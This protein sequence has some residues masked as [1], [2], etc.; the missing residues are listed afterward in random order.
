[1]PVIRIDGQ[2]YE[3][4]EGDNLLQAC[5]G[6]GLDLPYFCWHPAM[7]SI[8]A[9]RQCA[10]VQYQNAEDQ[11]GRLVMSCM[12]PVSDGAIFSLA[13]DKAATF[14]QA[15]IES[16]MTNHPH[17]CPVCAEGGEC[18][19]QDMTVM[20]GHRDRHYR[21]LKRTHRNQ[22]L[23]PLIQHEMNRCIACYRCT[24]YYRDYA[25]GTDL[26][27]MAAHNHVYFGRH[28]DGVLES[29]F[30]GNLVEV[31]PTGVF[32]D[33]PLQQEYTRKWDLQSAPSLCTGCA[34][35]CNT[36]AGER[37][38]K[39]KR[40][41]NRYN[42]EVNGYFLCDR[43]RF[44]ASFVNHKQ[45]LD[46]AGRRSANGRFDA[47]DS[48]QA[49]QHLAAACQRGGLAGIGSPRASVEANFLLR[50][51]VGA[52]NYSP[53]FSA[54]EQPLVE[55]A[56]SLQQ[57]TRALIP[58]IKQ[59]ESADAVFILGEDVTN[60]A[61]RIALALRQ[62]VR[63]IAYTMAAQLRLLPWQDA[64]VRN[65]AQEQ[66]NPLFIAA[67]ADTRLD[68]VAAAT[69]HLAPA[70]IARLGHAVAARIRT[71]RAHS[72][73]TLSPNKVSPNK[74]PPNEVMDEALQQQADT[75]ASALLDAKRP[76]LLSGTGCGSA[77]V[78]AAAADIA[79]ALGSPAAA[80]VTKGNVNNSDSDSDSDAENSSTT[81][82]KVDSDAAGPA[83]MLC[84]AVPEAN[85]LGQALLTGPSAPTLEALTVR[86]VGGEIQTLL[87]L[88]ND[89]YRRGP[90]A[91]IERLLQHVAEIIVI[92]SL[93]NPTLSASTLALPAASFAESEGTLVS[94]E[95]RAQRHFPVFLP[96][97]ERR[98][99]WQ[100]LLA[101]LQAISHPR[102]TDLQHFDDVTN[103]CASD[104]AALANITKAAPD[105]LFRNAGLAKVPRQPHRYSGRTAM[106]AN[107]SV[108]EPKQAAD[109]D[110][111]LAFSME[112]VNQFQPGALL[113]FVWAPGWNSNQSL[114][115]F[116]T[117]VGGPLKG[118]TAGAKLLQ[119]TGAADD[120]AAPLSPSA[121]KPVTGQWLL[122]PRYKIFGSEE[123]SAHSPAIA[124]LLLPAYLEITAADA[125][126]LQVDEGD[127]VQVMDSASGATLA[128]L[129]VRINDTMADGCAG[130]SVGH[131][132][133]Q[134]SIFNLV[135]G[136]GVALQKADPWQRRTQSAPGADLIATDSPT[137]SNTAAPGGP[138]H[139]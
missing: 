10:V 126:R 113:P 38:G 97:K 40:I 129:E 124:Q 132:A 57:Q 73:A 5:L 119:Q 138:N 83:V 100:W 14:R 84:L 15:I 32:T 55:L 13:G 23:G 93:D 112:G 108:H 37:Y 62:S 33:K 115:K 120:H 76:L 74:V 29:E 137:N 96:A 118:G 130:Y 9:C 18:H 125:E 19:L 59:I 28:E 54:A 104:I 79:A 63:N 30:A 111:A 50:T 80:T 135:A 2:D 77:A 61:P 47:I 72:P 67:L 58:S 70:D 11:R 110:S 98:A 44:G 114:H 16:L 101:C 127:G 81:A 89:L 106:G 48:D 6:L 94:M 43:G 24:R 109:E 64:A 53:G 39:L 41:H 123:L 82:S 35:G 75:I 51:L 31:C 107:V 85:S 4:K 133:H 65:L 26:A 25:G 1:M 49:L 36:L 128:T 7:G 45:R 27:A 78:M 88:E 34:V 42:S 121:F 8:G 46:W 95:G 52:D 22:N 21:G 117:E 56:L 103:A 87:V 71:A 131:S 99:S 3:V 66:R 116:Q 91:D 12:T 136:T 122:V 69:L 20:V 139:V 102:T 17:D 86:A 60:T 92:D 105:H 134:G 68:D 90:A